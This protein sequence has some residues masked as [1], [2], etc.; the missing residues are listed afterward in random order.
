MI[1]ADQFEKA[2][3]AFGAFHDD[4]DGDDNLPEDQRAIMLAAMAGIDPDMLQ[5]E[6]IGYARS[7]MHVVMET[8]MEGGPRMVAVNMATSFTIGFMLG[9][10]AARNEAEHAA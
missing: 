3:D 8:I 2:F 9:A 6:A 7:H 10:L 5:R 4:V 1:T